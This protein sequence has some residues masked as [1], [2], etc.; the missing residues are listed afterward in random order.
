M[1]LME[2]TPVEK[3]NINGIEFLVKREDLACPPP[4]PCFSKVR[5]LLSHMEKLK[6]TGIKT[7]GYVETAISMAGI[8]VAWVGRELRMEVI[9]YDPQYSLKHP[10]RNVHEFH[11]QKWQEFGA[12]I[13]PLRPFMTKVNYNIARKL[14]NEGPEREMLPLG[15]P[16]QETVEETAKQVLMTNLSEISTIV[17]CVGSG[18]ICS[19]VVKGIASLR[20]PPSVYGVMCRGGN[21]NQKEKRIRERAGIEKNGLVNIDLKIVNPGW[22]YIDREEIATPFPC[23]PYY[24]QKALRFLLD[25]YNRIR[26]LILFWNIGGG[27]D[28]APQTKN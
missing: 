23:N 1:K 4:G 11:R 20:N 2:T 19:G 9:I 22:E 25:N 10:A 6:Q 27:G 14:L 16:F 3:H 7:V 28:A 26:K 12:S 15:L 18:T 13:V 24:D 8:G 17:I 5:G 21:R